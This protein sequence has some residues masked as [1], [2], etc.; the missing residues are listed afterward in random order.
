M[1]RGSNS[2]HFRGFNI[3]LTL[4]ASHIQ[5][6]TISPRPYDSY[7]NRGRCLIYGVTVLKFIMHSNPAG[8]NVVSGHMVKEPYLQS[9]LKH[10]PAYTDSTR[11][12]SEHS[13][14]RLPLLEPTAAHL[15]ASYISITDMQHS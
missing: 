4:Q 10:P 13:C 1:W 11:L 2:R 12:A 14:Q 6:L 5:F 3:V 9:S 7:G 8:C 15:S